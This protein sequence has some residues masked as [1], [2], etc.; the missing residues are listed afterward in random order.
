MSE[1]STRDTHFAVFAKL[2]FDELLDVDDG[3][4][5][6]STYNQ[7]DDDMVEKYRRLIAQ[8]AYDLAMHVMKYTD[9]GFYPSSYFAGSKAINN[10][11]DLAELP[12]EG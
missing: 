7:A 11:P 4:I 8:R 6:V 5:D 9:G 3:H 2:L 12:K 10:V 1:Q